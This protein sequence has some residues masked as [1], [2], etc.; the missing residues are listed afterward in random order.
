MSSLIVHR[1]HKEYPTILGAAPLVVLRDFSLEMGAGQS[2]A[3][4]GPSGSGKSTLLSILGTLEQPTSGSVRL[5]N[6]ELTTLGPAELAAVRRDRIGFVFQEHC[7]MPQCTA[8]ENLLVP[9]L[10][11]GA[12]DDAAVDRAM[13][14]LRR[15]GLS[16]RME[17]FPAQLSGGERQRV[18]VARALM[19][20]PVIVL[21]DEPTGNLDPHVADAVTQLLVE[22]AS[23]AIL[24]I[25][26]HS[27]AVAARMQRTLPLGD[28][29]LIKH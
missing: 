25:V 18:A 3:V 11:D 5:D 27:A 4:T 2:L 23:D 10:A 29:A 6:V 7:L 20:R 17:H 26:T 9:I 1:I 28:D 13:E 19:R 14:L 15:V 22:M 12:A 24:I 8:L 21:A 16:E